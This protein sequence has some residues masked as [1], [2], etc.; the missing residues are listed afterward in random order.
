[1]RLSTLAA[2]ALLA[3]ACQDGAP[4]TGPKPA[5]RTA[6]LV[7]ASPAEGARDVPASTRVLVRFSSPILADQAPSALRLTD[8]AGAPVAA[9]ITPAGDGTALVLTPDA[10]LVAGAQ[11]GVTVTPV[12]ELAPR[13]WS[14]QVAA[15]GPRTGDGVRVV[16]VLPMDAP[17]GVVWPFS[18]L[19]VLFSE[20]VRSE[21][22]SA[23]VRLV[24]A[25]SGE[26]VKGTLLARG[27]R[28]VFDPNED[29]EPGAS[30][31]LELTRDLLDLAGE[32]LTPVTRELTVKPAPLR[33]AVTLAL[34]EQARPAGTASR[35]DLRP[36]NTLELRSALVGTQSLG[37]SGV[38]ATELPDLGELGARV[39]L[40]VRKGQRLTLTVADPRGLP[41]SLY[42]QIPTGLFSGP[43]SMELL[44]DAVGEISESP[45]AA[46]A[47]SAPPLVRM[48]LDASLSAGDA[49]V[50][51]LLNQDLLHLELSGLL[52]VQDGRLFVDLVGGAELEL[53]GM[54]T[55]GSY[56]TLA[57]ASVE[58]VDGLTAEPL[59]LRASLPLEGAREVPVD[60]ELRVVLSS[61]VEES[62]FARF[63]WLEM[64]PGD[65]NPGS[66][67]DVRGA[68]RQDGAT[69]YF[70]PYLPLEPGTVYKLQLDPLLR[71]AA[72]AKLGEAATVSFTTRKL[73][74]AAPRPPMV[75]A[76][77]P[78]VPCALLST[79]EGLRCALELVP[80]TPASLP[81]D[82][83]LEVAFTRP[84]DPS[85]VQLH[86]SFS[87]TASDGGTPAGRLQ[88]SAGLVRFVPDVPLREGE[89]YRLVLNGRADAG[90]GPDRICD[91]EGVPLNTDV[92]QDAL[93]EAGGSP[94]EVLFTASPAAHESA[95]AL[96]L[97]PAADLNANGKIDSL[98]EVARDENSVSM[99][100]P[101]GGVAARTYLAGSMLATVGAY[102]SVQDGVRVTVA[103]GSWMFG[104]STV[105]FGLVTDRLI[106]RPAQTAQGWLRRP[107]AEDPD[108]R[109]VVSVGFRAYV[110]A[111][112]D[113]VEQALQREPMELQLQ[114]RLIFGADGTLVMELTNANSTTLSLLQGN[115][116]LSI[117]PGDVRV[118]AVSPP[119]KR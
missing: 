66:A 70:R 73:S 44:T 62:T 10:P 28:L 16:S 2:L 39:P 60:G 1:M 43:L 85:T 35:L 18:T 38:L 102:D 49:T 110:D 36:S 48:V 74:A 83:P 108:R 54:E 103:Q 42:G 68:V 105:M 116:V 33:R 55:A 22:A 87:F 107:A 13:T 67:D 84:V 86:R 12:A 98:N 29:L 89:S 118:R 21:T 20:P 11:Y 57:A 112:N 40:A 78:G 82:Q 99:R 100:G 50:H 111:V 52:Q 64:G 104:T 3:A 56:V 59:R 37:I 95:M 46:Q 23:S 65:G 53:L 80:A 88:V 94:L 92:L 106:I 27:T 24:K 7:F 8:A 75:A 117:Q 101:D 25:S 113:T 61:P 51:T 14:F 115:L 17:A 4:W 76:V 47:P 90:C 58:P 15:G 119:L 71:S 114:G 5:V 63:I 19:H 31:R 26:V 30:Y 81:A 91:P 32:P 45:Y 93:E 72:G 41:I 69:V 34:G 9:K 6:A 77:R 109:P 79:P 96:Q 97:A